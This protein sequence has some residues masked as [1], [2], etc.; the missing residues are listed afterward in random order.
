MTSSPSAASTSE[1]PLS[2]D[3][4]VVASSAESLGTRRADW[5]MPAA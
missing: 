4:V 2:E 5:R 1:S 3:G